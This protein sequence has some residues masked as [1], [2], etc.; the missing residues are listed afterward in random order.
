MGQGT[1][2]IKSDPK[3]F[4]AALIKLLQG[5]TASGKLKFCLWTFNIPIVVW[6]ELVKLTDEFSQLLKFSFISVPTLK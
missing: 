1:F 4:G 6:Y 2:I 3:A 5:T